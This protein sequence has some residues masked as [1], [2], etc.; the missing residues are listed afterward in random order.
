[1]LVWNVLTEILGGVELQPAGQ[2]ADQVD[3]GRH[4]RAGI[5]NTGC[6]GGL[7]LEVT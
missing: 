7:P 3:V 6:V 2:V 1:M 4:R 5:G